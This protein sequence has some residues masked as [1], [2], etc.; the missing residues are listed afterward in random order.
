MTNEAWLEALKNKLGDLDERDRQTVEAVLKILKTGSEAAI[1]AIAHSLLLKPT[2]FPSEFV[3]ENLIAQ[4]YLALPQDDRFDLQCALLDLN[5]DWL[6]QTFDELGAAWIMVVDGEVVAWSPD[7]DQYPQEAEVLAVCHETGKFP[8]VFDDERLLQIEEASTAWSATHYPGDTYPTATI[9]VSA[10]G[11]T[12][13]LTA[14][15]DSGALD[16]FFDLDELTSKG[17]V[18][19]TPTEVPTRGFHLNKLYRRFRKTLQVGL[20]ADD[21]TVRRQTMSAICVQ[22]WQASPFVDINPNRTALVGRRLFHLLQPTMTLNFAAQT[23]H[24]AF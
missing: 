9:E 21:G 1:P 24:V 19:M 11:A 8:F 22:H 4:E 5:A 2:R 20:V 14:D 13:N 12:V 23:T 17:L 16:L 18:Q 3:G 10:A 7:V 15:F 6:N